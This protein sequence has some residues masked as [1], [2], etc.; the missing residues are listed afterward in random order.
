MKLKLKGHRFGTVE[1][2]QTESYRVP[3]T[4]REKYFRKASKN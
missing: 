4:L 2:I 1:E 3:D